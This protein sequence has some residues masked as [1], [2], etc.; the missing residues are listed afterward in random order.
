VTDVIFDGKPVATVRPYGTH[1]ITNVIWKAA[2]PGEMHGQTAVECA[3]QLHGAI[4]HRLDEIETVRVGTHESALRI[5]DKPGPLRNAADR[6]HC[7]QYMV[8]VALVHGELTSRHYEDEIAADPRID[9]LRARTTVTENPRFT[10]DYMAEDKRSVANTVEIDFR[11]GSTLGPVTVEYPIGHPRRRVE[12]VDAVQRKFEAAFEQVYPAGRYEEAL[13]VTSD[14]ARLERTPVH[15]FMAMLSMPGGAQD[16][17][18]GP[19]RATKA[20]AAGQ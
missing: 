5:I 20:G 19:A 12:G 4:R 13:T 11:D 1:T 3:L 16:G 7:L 17:P 10:R 8:A 9:H 2:F 6:D 18:A 14:Q 15:D